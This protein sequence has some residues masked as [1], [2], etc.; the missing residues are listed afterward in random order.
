MSTEMRIPVASDRDIISARQAGKQLSGA[1]GFSAVQTTLIV[2]AISEV[3]R[4]ILEYARRGT[5]LL[6][7]IQEGDRAGIVIVASD[8]GPGIPDVE[9]AMQDGYSTGKGLGLGLPGARRMMDEFVL[10][11][12]VGHGTTITM[13]KWVTT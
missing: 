9:R 7:A 12:R 5:I 4:N 2:T 8:E 3:A 10:D 1:L 13:K 11:T 6:R